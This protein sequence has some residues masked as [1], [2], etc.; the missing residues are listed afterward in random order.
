[1]LRRKQD[2]EPD[3]KVSGFLSIGGTTV[4]FVALIVTT[5]AIAAVTMVMM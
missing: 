5:L 2:A 3:S 4:A 1:M